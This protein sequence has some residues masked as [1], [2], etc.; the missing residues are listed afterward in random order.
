MNRA[1]IFCVLLLAAAT[2]LGGCKKEPLTTIAEEPGLQ[3]TEG[4][5]V[6]VQLTEPLK[7]TPSVEP[8][9]VA[10]DFSN[11]AN[12]QQIPE[13][14]AEQK[15]LLA[16]NAFLVVPDTKEQLFYVYEDNRY[17]DPQI[18]SFI[19]CDTVLQ[20][21][22]IFYDYVLRTVES[23][24]LSPILND[25]TRTMLKE[26]IQ[27]WKQISDPELKE[28]ALRNIAYFGVADRLLGKNSPL[29]S[30]AQTMV[31]KEV[32]MIMAHAQREKSAIFPYMLEYTQFQPRGHYTRSENLQKFFRTMMW[33]GL[34]P[35][36]FEWKWQE[37]DVS[38][39]LVRQGVLT[40]HLTFNSKSGTTPTIDLWDRIY[41]PTK[42]FVGA[43]DD[44]EV[45]EY[46]Q[47]MERVYGEQ[48]SLKDF[49]DR[50]KL[51]K[52]IA[53]KDNLRQPRIEQIIIGIPTGIQMRFMPQRFI[54]DSR[55]MQELC[56][57]KVKG[58]PENPEAQRLFP[59]GLDVMSALG[60]RRA[61]QIL[62]QV[63]QEAKYQGYDKQ[64]QKMRDEI[65]SLDENT[66]RS[67]LYYGW[68]Y[69][70][71]PLLEEK[72]D[73]YP[74][75]MTN[76]AWLD[77]QINTSLA[78]W[79]ELRHD[80]ILYGKQSGAEAGDGGPPPKGYVEPEAE[81]YSR[82]LWLVSTTAQGLEERKLITP[83]LKEAFSNFQEMLAFLRDVS[84]K[85]LTNQKL[86]DE[87]Y[88]RIGG[89]GGWLEHLSLRVVTAVGA[90]R[91]GIAHW[92]E[93]TSKADRD[94]AVVADVHT[95]FGKCLEEAVG[96]ANFIYAIVPIEGKLYLTRGASFSY[97]EF[98]WPTAN[99][100]TDE[101]WQQLLEEKKA[102]DPPS[103]TKSFLLAGG[104]E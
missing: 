57:P 33:Y 84:V 60:S 68:L 20:L 103:W 14:S 50:K 90:E 49:A 13:F 41:G 67:N 86:T 10:A 85:E 83:E 75:F 58:T 76:N 44:L 73:G 80:T 12:R 30:Q 38:E 91:G 78:S 72:G 94:M 79:A 40:T 23:E 48:A 27:A 47:A 34:V 22:H 17:A 42:F 88:Q 65:A 19:T 92:Y 7:I 52:F 29:P 24:K 81:F 15:G 51:A 36:P 18:P 93:I 98:Q 95:S 61:Y 2:C 8:Y 70:L 6:Q 21:Y 71:L 39:D 69:C 63:Y 1:R 56:W 28:A 82:L 25:L 26:S 104:K 4:R 66:W 64:M 46:R 96:H 45:R 99:R 53:L 89:Y 100:L 55:I 11:V 5:L 62:D 9:Q 16:Q 32:K 43:A 87:E 37:K 101:Q 102:P 59:R 77:K 54:P 3:L 35:F 31:A 97:Y 74:S